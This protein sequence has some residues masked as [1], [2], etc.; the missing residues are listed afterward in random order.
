MKW[1]A[2]TRLKRWLALAEYDGHIDADG[3]KVGGFNKSTRKV[4]DR[5]LF[6]HMQMDAIK[7]NNTISK[8]LSNALNTLTSFAIA[9]SSMGISKTLFSR[10]RN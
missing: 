2:M 10:P 7:N 1:E 9:L 6:N 8:K 5:F 4:I 3:K